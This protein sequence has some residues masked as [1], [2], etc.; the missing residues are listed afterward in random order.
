ML[1]VHGRT[2]VRMAI[3]AAEHCIVVRIRVAIAAAG[4]R[5]A[6]IAGIDREIRPVMIVCRSP[7]EGRV[8]QRTIRRKTCARMIRILRRVVIIFVTEEAGCG[9]AL[10]L[11]V[12]MALSA[13]HA[14]MRAREWEIRV[15]VIEGG[16]I[17]PIG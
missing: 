16:R 17:P 3:N 5:R 13:R 6:V 4:P 2:Q 10:I 8:A 7:V 1:V 9:R 14:H 11:A 15:A 12:E